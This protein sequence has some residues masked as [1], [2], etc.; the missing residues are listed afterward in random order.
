MFS[1]SGVNRAIF[2]NATSDSEAT[3]TVGEAPPNV[4]F[5]DNEMASRLTCSICFEP[6][7]NTKRA[8][9]KD[10]YLC[11]Q[12][13]EK[14]NVF[15]GDGAKP[16]CPQCRDPILVNGDGSRGV[17]SPFMDLVVSQS[18]AACGEVGCTAT[19]PF[20]NAKAHQ[21][22]CPCKVVACPF[23]SM[24]CTHKCK[25]S[26]MKSHI[27][28]TSDVHTRL[29]LD[30]FNQE[31]EEMR[32]KQA[33][34]ARFVR[35]SYNNVCAF[36]ARHFEDHTATVNAIC[37]VV[38]KLADSVALLDKKVSGIAEQLE[39]AGY[40]S[41]RIMDSS[42]GANGLGEPCSPPAKKQQSSPVA[43]GAPRRLSAP[44]PYE[45]R[46]TWPALQDDGLGLLESPEPL[47]ESANDGAFR[48]WD[49]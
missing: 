35:S 43:P 4:L 29:L 40:K 39:E 19:F 8:C 23:A 48:G 38:N 47:E 34:L 1:T 2:G 24:G 20:M 33:S 15:G 46:L 25:R 44:G 28:Q 37:S 30:N 10:H 9:T 41:K 27:E 3:S 26:D 36:Q 6:L 11:G 21:S 16:L 5:V 13:I 14:V 32:Y 31:T 22:V 12:C 7:S 42:E 17:Q 18:W 49:L 45:G